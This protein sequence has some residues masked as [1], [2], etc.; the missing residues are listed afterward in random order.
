MSRQ[1]HNSL[2]RI[3]TADGSPFGISFRNDKQ[4]IVCTEITKLP[5]DVAPVRLVQT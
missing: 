4:D 5:L 2:I 3:L 1:L